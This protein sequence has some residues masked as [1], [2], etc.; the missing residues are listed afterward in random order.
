MIIT[1]NAGAR[2]NKYLQSFLAAMLTLTGTAA[3]GLTLGW[4]LGGISVNFRF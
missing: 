4:F 2:L 1:T 3:L